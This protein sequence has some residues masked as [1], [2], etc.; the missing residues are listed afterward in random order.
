MGYFARMRSQLIIELVLLFFIIVLHMHYEPYFDPRANNFRIA[1][2]TLPFLSILVA[3]ICW[4]SGLSE[5][6]T[7]WAPV[8]LLIA[9]VPVGLIGGWIL[10]VFTR[11]HKVRRIMMN[12]QNKYQVGAKDI[13]GGV[14]PDKKI[15]RTVIAGNGNSRRSSSRRQSIMSKTMSLATG[16]D[17]K[18]L[19]EDIESIA[20]AMMERYG[21]AVEKKAVRVPNVFRNPAEADLAMRFLRDSEATSG[22]IQIM[23][24]VFGEA[25]EV[26]DFVCDFLL[27]V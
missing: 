25:M 23:H 13:E 8:V 9:T 12:I 11:R 4:F 15:L 7:S 6:Q 1:F 24:I 14:T 3:T 5:S 27:I 22:A 19:I 17:S 26:W 10:A 2:F 16:E 18:E 20:A 21:Q